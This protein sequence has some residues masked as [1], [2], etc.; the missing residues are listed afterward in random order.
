[1]DSSIAL[2]GQGEEGTTVGRTFLLS[3]TAFSLNER[4]EYKNVS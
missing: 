4:R 1:M 2:E 3:Y